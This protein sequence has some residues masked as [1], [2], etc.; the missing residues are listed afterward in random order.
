MK[1]SIVV[2]VLGFLLSCSSTRSFQSFFDEHKND[3]GVTAF[4]VP[5]FMRSMLSS[6]S[7]EMGGIFQNI[8]DFKFLTFNEISPEKK[9]LLIEQMNTVTSNKYTDI[10]RKNTTDKTKI[11]S[12]I[13]DGDRVKE[14]IIF[15][16][17]LD[18][19]SV[20]FLK[21]SFDPV[22][23][24]K[25]SETEQFDD[26]SSELLKGNFMQTTTPG[27]NPNGN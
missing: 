15:N 8:Q 25:I 4:Q 26:L 17:T 27:F 2:F 11:L 3:V 16:S 9:A 20:F 5:N 23:L 13:E 19:S 24:K 7:P 18:K 22:Q 1:K 6:I 10:L 14:A 12:V 21:G